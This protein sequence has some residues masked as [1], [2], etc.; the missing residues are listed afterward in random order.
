[1]H[2]RVNEKKSNDNFN[3]VEELLDLRQLVFTTD[4]VVLKELKNV[5]EVNSVKWVK[6]DSVGTNRAP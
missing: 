1:M 4:E 2:E 5:D 3:N 6:L